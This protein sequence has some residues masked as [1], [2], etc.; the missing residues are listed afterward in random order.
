MAQ[1]KSNKSNVRGIPSFWQNHTVDS[2]IP[3]KEWSDLF[4]FAVI[5]KEITDIENLLNPIERI[6]HKHQ[7]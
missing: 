7:S 5:A 1:S 6:I 4:P 3:W 2:P